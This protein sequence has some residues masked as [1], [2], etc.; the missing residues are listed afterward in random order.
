MNNKFK[1]LLSVLLLFSCKT[2]A[3]VPCEKKLNVE[4]Q[5]MNLSLKAPK[6]YG[7]KKWFKIPESDFNTSKYRHPLENGSWLDLVVQKQSCQVLDAKIV[8]Q[9]DFS[10]GVKEQ[11]SDLNLQDL[12]RKN[13]STL[14]YYWSPQMI[15]SMTELNNLRKIAK[16]LSLDLILFHEAQFKL[17]S[18]DQRKLASV[19]ITQATVSD[20]KAN[21][22]NYLKYSHTIQHFPLL[23]LVQNGKISPKVVPGVMPYELWK[24]EISAWSKVH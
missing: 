9:T 8:G 4:A 11:F 2:F 24:K 18:Y 15:Y 21:F 16:E 3:K 22:S 12:S 19:G 14:I 13:K 7:V 17:D 5:K 10:A 6:Y 20:S 1:I 23:F